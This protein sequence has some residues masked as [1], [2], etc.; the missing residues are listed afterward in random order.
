MNWSPFCRSVNIGTGLDFLVH[1]ICEQ[2]GYNLVIIARSTTKIEIV[3][4]VI[5]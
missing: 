3:T 1:P 4:D 2:K 5:D